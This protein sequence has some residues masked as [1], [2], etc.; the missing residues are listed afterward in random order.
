MRFFVTGATGYIGEHVAA[1]LDDQGHDVLGLARSESSA[2][3]LLDRGYE[4]HRGDLCN[5]GSLQS[6][7]M[8]ADATIH[9][10]FS[11][12]PEKA[13]ALEQ[14][15][16]TAM[17]DTVTQTGTTFVYTSDVLLYGETET[18]AVDEQTPLDPDAYPW[19]AN[20]ERAVRAADGDNGAETTALR[21]G[22][23]YGDGGNDL[24]NAIMNRSR[25]REAAYY[26][27]DGT[28]E[29]ATV[30]VE[31]LAKLYESVVRGCEHGLYNAV[32]RHTRMRSFAA[33]VGDY[34]EIPVKSI[35]AEKASDEM[36]L[37]GELGKHQ[38]I[39]AERARSEFTWKPTA[40]PLPEAVLEGEIA[41]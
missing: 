19:R 10:A 11:D 22:M 20:V 14:D 16:V 17:L 1:V 9:T 38:R 41:R 31:E 26:V 32:S 24:L 36:I 35:T 5:K 37:G 15:A 12:D 7:V 21:V 27:G 2:E 23:V 3:Q 8:D 39:S 18:E 34:Y 40:R 13:A 30:H 33:A 29:W 4:V 6:G 25:N 28:N